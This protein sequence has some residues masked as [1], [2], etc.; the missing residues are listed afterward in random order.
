M[1]DRPIIFSA[2]MVRALLDGTKTQTRRI[3]KGV[4]RDNNMVLKKATRTRIGITT[5]VID[6]PKH[7]LLPYA[8]GD[9]LWVREA[10]RGDRGY[11]TTPPRQWSRWPV[12]YEAD[13]KRDTREGMGADGRLRSPI[14][15]PRWASRITLTVTDVRVQRL[16]EISGADAVEEGVQEK[17]DYL[18]MP[19]MAF[20]ALWNSLHGPDAWDANPWVVAVSFTVRHGNIDDA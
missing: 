6:A 8:H 13:G 15:M 16:Q 19:R 1:T 18:D 14:H 7:G 17:G 20:R 9:R 4:R 5:H 3:I 11:D 12:H 2:P 10:F